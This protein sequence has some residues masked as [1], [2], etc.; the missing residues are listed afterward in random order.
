MSQKRNQYLNL[1]FF[2]TFE[3]NSTRNKKVMGKLYFTGKSIT[4]LCSFQDIQAESSPVFSEADVRKGF[5]LAR[6]GL[7]LLCD[8][9]KVQYYCRVRGYS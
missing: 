5:T 8:T 2:V 3:L 4:M 1:N 9:G 6:T 7:Y